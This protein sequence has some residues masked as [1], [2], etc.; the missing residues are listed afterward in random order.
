V[1]V[2]VSLLNTVEARQCPVR[3]GVASPGLAGQGKVLITTNHSRRGW[4]RLGWVGLVE[5]RQCRDFTDDTKT[6][7][8]FTVCEEQRHSDP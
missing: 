1:S 2:T 5:A 4:A 7:D 3:L 6:N 8:S